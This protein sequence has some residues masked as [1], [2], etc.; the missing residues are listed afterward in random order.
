MPEKRRGEGEGWIGWLGGGDGGG[1]VNIRLFTYIIR[2]PCA[3]QCNNIFYLG[4]HSQSFFF[5]YL[6]FFVD[7]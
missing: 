6:I 4:Y 5:S 7:F 1:E 2:R 3:R